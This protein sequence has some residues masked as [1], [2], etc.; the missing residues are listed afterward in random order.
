MGHRRGVNPRT[1]AITADRVSSAGVVIALVVAAVLAMIVERHF[2]DGPGP[3]PLA[4]GAR[5][6]PFS[7]PTG[8]PPRLEDQVANLMAGERGRIARMIYDAPG[9]TPDVTVTRQTADRSWVFGVAAL[10]V[11]TSSPA[12]PQ[13]AL[14]LAHW[15]GRRWRAGISGGEDFRALLRVV[16]TR[17]LPATEIRA[18]ARFSVG[19]VR[20]PKIRLPWQVGESRR[21]DTMA[22]PLAF[23][24]AN[25]QV[26]AAT[27]GTI[28]RFCADSADNGLLMIINTSGLATLY[29]RL[30]DLTRVSDGTFVRKGDYLG[31]PGGPGTCGGA[32]SPTVLF[33][34]GQGDGAIALSG[35]SVGGWNF[36][37]GWA[38]RGDQQVMPGQ[39]LSNLDS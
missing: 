6:I 37:D 8:R 39:M 30:A 36:R 25:G 35:R 4:S 27:D 32:T 26:L 21:A 28:Y 22:G 17:L 33:G 19:P 20:I 15:E 5:T 1:V 11:P 38:Q 31:Q 16:P 14:F 10:P 12:M 18:L 13:V 3:T 24:G 7:Q 9:G 34:L 29:Y 2:L 23:D